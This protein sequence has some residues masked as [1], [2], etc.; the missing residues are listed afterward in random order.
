MKADRHNTGKLK[1]SLVEFSSLE[2]M[3]RVLEF[4]AEKYSPDNWKKGLDQKEI[5]ESMLRHIFAYMRG[6]KM[7]PES[8]LP[9]VGHIQCN[10]MF[11]AYM[12]NKPTP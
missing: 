11:L 8:G 4:G 12:D 5:V 2:D 1:W 6:E 10:A 9:H 7:D 3:V